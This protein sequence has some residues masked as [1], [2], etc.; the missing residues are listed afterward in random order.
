MEKSILQSKSFGLS[1]SVYQKVTE[2]QK[3]QKEFLLTQWWAE[4]VTS[5]ALNMY[6][7]S[8]LHVKRGLAMYFYT[9][10]KAT[11]KSIF[12]TKL[13]LEAGYLDKTEGEMIQQSLI[14]L[15]KMIQASI[16]TVVANRGKKQKAENG[17][18]IS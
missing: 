1:V 3:K 17:T 5:I 11:H 15:I 18:T 16:T 8:E 4:S 12:W 10:R 9:A 14:E 6:L 13:L 2:L 7:A